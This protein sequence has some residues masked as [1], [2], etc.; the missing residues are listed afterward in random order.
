M[1]LLEVI[2]GIGK[3][4]NEF[5][6]FQ[7]ADQAVV[8]YIATL[9]IVRLQER[10]PD[11]KI[12]LRATGRYIHAGFVVNCRSG[13]RRPKSLAWRP[14][15]PLAARSD[16]FRAARNARHLAKK[17]QVVLCRWEG[18]SIQAAQPSCTTFII[19]N[20]RSCPS[21]SG[22]MIDWPSRRPTRPAP[23]GVRIE[24]RPADMS[25]SAG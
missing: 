17:I 7:M 10:F 8:V 15:S 24:I 9:A 18:S 12:R 4:A 3:E 20:R 23:I 6:A 11:A 13:R 1:D 16:Q 25:A 19:T 5:G 22:H 14:G 2:L 21:R